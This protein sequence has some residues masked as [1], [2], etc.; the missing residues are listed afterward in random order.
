MPSRGSSAREIVDRHERALDPGHR[1]GL[2][3]H[4]TPEPLARRL[5]RLALAVFAEGGADGPP[6]VVCDPCCGAGSVLLAAAEELVGLGIPPTDVVTERLLGVEIDPAAAEAATEALRSW[7]QQQGVASSVHPRIV[8]A[9]SL[10]APREWAGPWHERIDVIVGNPPFLTPL[11]ADTAPARVARLGASAT[12]LAGLGPYT[13]AAAVHLLAA[14]EAV[15]PGGSVCLLQPQSVLGARD[16]SV[17]RG[18]LWERGDL[19][20]LWV[21][22]SQQFEAQVEVCAPVLVRRRAAQPPAGPPGQVRVMWGDRPAQLVDLPDPAQG[23]APL[24]GA[25]LGVPPVLTDRSPAGTLGELARI[26]AGFR[27][28]FYALC[29]AAEDDADGAGP[30]L[31]TSG[32]VD[33]GHLGW[34]HQ[35]RRLGG[36]QMVAPRV[37][38]D[39]VDAEH[40]AVGRWARQRL[41]PK[42]MVAS[43]TKVIEAVVDHE[44]DCV[45]VTP[46]ISVEPT[47]PGVTPVMLAVALS[48]PV[49]SACLA[50]AAAG[51]GRSSGAMRVAARTLAALPVPGDLTALRRAAEVWAAL[52]AEAATAGDG[53]PDPSA[54]RR[55]RWRRLGERLDAAMGV[56]EPAV[57][58]WW[59]DRLP[60]LRPPRRATRRSTRADPRA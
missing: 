40:A 51:T 60:A 59:L 41:G 53:G 16:A 44:G 17:A 54:G 13:D 58:D 1:R 52:E 48:A 45:P 32:M 30:R 43:Q 14:I 42:A 38:L 3:A 56:Q 50:S 55:A 26:T 9:D 10:E 20:A 11:A 25:A 34:G 27:D 36:R 37:D 2:G 7:A 21:A 47:E 33:P 4:Y 46:V 18:R 12:T 5:A 6:R 28:E 22:G 15:A 35:P 24:L 39:R 19:V 57:V 31:V 8:V 29:G 49:S 23:W